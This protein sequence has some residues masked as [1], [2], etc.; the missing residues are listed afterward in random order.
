[1]K[2]PIKVYKILS[3]EEELQ[4][5]LIKKIDTDL[6]KQFKKSLDDIKSGRITRVA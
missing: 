3:P 4:L 2:V 1:M 5:L 6:I